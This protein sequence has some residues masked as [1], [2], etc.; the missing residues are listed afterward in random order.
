[1]LLTILLIPFVAYFYTTGHD[2]PPDDFSD[3]APAPM[4]EV[5]DGDNAHTYFAQLPDAFVY[6]NP[7]NNLPTD[8]M[9]CHFKNVGTNLTELA[10]ALAENEAALGL[11]RRA[12]ECEHRVPPP[13]AANLNELLAIP[14]DGALFMANILLLASI[15]FGI[16]TGDFDAAIGDMRTLLRC[17]KL[18]RQ[19]PGAM[20]NWISGNVL[21]RAALAEIRNLARDPRLSEQ[22]LRRLAKLSGEIPSYTSSMREAFKAEVVVGLVINDEFIAE[23][24]ANLDGKSPAEKM[25]RSFFFKH[26]YLPNRTRLLI[27]E[28][29]R[30]AIRE[31]PKPYS[32]AER[33][34]DPDYGKP[35]VVHLLLANNAYGKLLASTALVSIES[36]VGN[37]CAFDGEVNATK[38]TVACNLFRKVTGR[39][40]LALDELVPDYLDSVPPDPF[41]DAPFRYNHDL[42]VVYSVGTSLSD[43][44]GVGTPMTGG[45]NWRHNRNA[46]FKLWED[47]VR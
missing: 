40:P 17:G 29:Y 41:D 44:G 34:V 3:L 38:I 13:V 43:L 12:A 16:D 11:L 36:A 14:Y 28:T 20:I 26:H 15:K 37:R 33:L 39:K 10:Q 24:Y 25:V 32:E 6:P 9:R 42:G 46:I 4:A 5:A 21:D 19:N 18:A 27:A 45:L 8:A 47:I 22:Q 1:M 2:I 23:M 7:D 31:L 30:S 35:S